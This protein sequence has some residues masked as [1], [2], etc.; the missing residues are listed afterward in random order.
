RM[1]ETVI[2]REGAWA[3]M[4]PDAHFMSYGLGWF[5]S[6]YHGYQMLQ[7]GGGI[8]GMSAMVGLMPEIGAGVVILSNLNGN[9]LPGSLM[10]RVFDAYLGRPAKDW[11]EESRAMVTAGIKA[12]EDAE[13]ARQKGVVAGTKPTLAL[14]S[15]VGTYRH[16][17]WGDLVI[18]ARGD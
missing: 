4:T 12:G 18:S 8:D 1:P 13:A 15:Y 16:P 11:S 17:A 6:D 2:R 5:L 14:A 7:H 9:L 10:H 3:L